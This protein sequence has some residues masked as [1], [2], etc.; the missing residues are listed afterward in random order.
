MSD[1]TCSIDG[2]T[3][4]TRTLGLCSRHYQR[5]HRHG[6][7]LGGGAYRDR[8]NSPTPCSIAE[9]T[10][11][12]VARGWCPIH[13]DT[14][15]R[16][17][18]PTWTPPVECSIPG[19]ERPRRSRGWCNRHY[20]TW[21]AHGDPLYIRVRPTTPERFW[22]KVD[23]NGPVP[24]ARPDLGRCWVWTANINDGGYGMFNPGSK[25]T[26]VAHRWAYRHMVGPIPR[27][28]QLD[29]LCRNRACVNPGHLDPV[30]GRINVLRGET[31]PAANAIKTHCP[32][33]HPYDEANTRVDRLGR[34]SCRA[35]ER[36]RAR[37]AWRMKNCGTVEDRPAA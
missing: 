4:P 5:Q 28:L 11:I 31:L 26:E 2:C 9:C 30:T 32:Q 16:H 29:H 19:C 14:W 23:K 34:R 36:I 33:N 6:D 18:D 7:P 24:E 8:P 13:Y 27:G 20:D 15:R 12:A 21:L 35:C 37:N 25:R 22:A 3:R 10:E 1:R 17:G